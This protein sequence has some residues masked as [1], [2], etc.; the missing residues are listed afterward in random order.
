[1]I[2]LKVFTN[3]ENWQKNT[4]D[5]FLKLSQIMRNLDDK[6]W[7]KKNIHD[8][9]EAF[10]NCVKNAKWTQNICNWFLLSIHNR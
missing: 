1:M 2:H 6:N 8:P 10:T 7:L 3:Q 9:L 4:C 5:L